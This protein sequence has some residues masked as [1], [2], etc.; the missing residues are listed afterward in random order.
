M[1][2]DVLISHQVKRLAILHDVM[3]LNENFVCLFG[4]ASV[5]GVYT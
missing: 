2:G 5:D 4:I 3:G 1:K